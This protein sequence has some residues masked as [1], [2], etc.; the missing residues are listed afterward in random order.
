MGGR[1]KDNI[2][3]NQGGVGGSGGSME[4]SELLGVDIATPSSKSNNTFNTNINANSNTI[5]KSNDDT[6]RIVEGSIQSEVSDAPNQ[7]QNQQMV[8]ILQAQRDRY[9]DRQAA[10]RHCSHAHTDT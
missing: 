1:R 2:A 6:V 10:V 3:S 5:T 7:R 8:D 4:L 9:K